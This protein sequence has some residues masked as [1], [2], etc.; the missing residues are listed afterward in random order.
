MSL[1]KKIQS[2]LLDENEKIF[3]KSNN[4]LFNK[5]SE[6]TIFIECTED[7]FYLKL[8]TLVYCKKVKI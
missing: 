2:L 5:K 6:N 3:I 7:Y 8:Y 1:I 4:I